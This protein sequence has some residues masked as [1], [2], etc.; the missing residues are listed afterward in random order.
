MAPANGEMLKVYNLVCSLVQFN[1]RCI[2]F[3]RYIAFM[4]CLF[5]MVFDLIK[6]IFSN[7]FVINRN[8]ILYSL[9]RSNHRRCSLRKG[10]PR[11]FTK[12]TG[13]FLWILRNFSEHLSYRTPPMAA[14]AQLEGEEGVGGLPC[15]FLKIEKV[16]LEYLGKETP[17]FYLRGLFFLC[18]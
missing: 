12:F 17:K 4:N 16:A 3:E 6:L 15:S 5:I 13:V 10:V 2:S 9:F 14:A 1:H 8:N 18:F 11:N 7:F